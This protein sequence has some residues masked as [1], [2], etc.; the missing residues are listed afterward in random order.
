MYGDR[1]D[2]AF[3]QPPSNAASDKQ[4]RKF[5]RNTLKVIFCRLKHFEAL[6]LIFLYI[7]NRVGTAPP[8]LSLIEEACAQQWDAHYESIIGKYL[9]IISP[10]NKLS[11]MDD[12][13]W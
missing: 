5:S 12:Q 2:V 3:Q 7:L 13:F 11:K 6:N 1:N 9:T 4:V 8:A 10:D